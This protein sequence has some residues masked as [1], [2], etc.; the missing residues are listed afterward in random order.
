MDLQMKKIP[1]TVLLTLMLGLL[2]GTVLAEAPPAPDL[3][4]GSGTFLSEESRTAEKRPGAAEILQSSFVYGKEVP[5][6]SYRSFTNDSVPK[7]LYKPRDSGEDTYQE[8][9][10]QAVG[11]YT[12]KVIYPETDTHLE[13]A[14]TADFTIKAY[15]SGLQLLPGATL[16]GRVY[17]GSTNNVPLPPELPLDFTLEG[18]DR[19]PRLGED[20]EISAH[21]L[22][23]QVD[24][25]P[26]SKNVLL[27][28]SFI[29]ELYEAAPELKRELSLHGD[30]LKAPL[31]VTAKDQYAK[32][33]WAQDLNQVSLQGLAQ[34]DSLREI[35]LSLDDSRLVPEGAKILRGQEDVTDQYT[36]AYQPGH[37]H[38]SASIELFPAAA[39]DLFYNGQPQTLLN[40]PGKAENGVLMYRVSHSASQ[41]LPPSLISDWSEALP[42]GIAPGIYTVQFLA[43]NPNLHDSEEGSL[44][45]I[46]SPRILTITA[47][48]E[49]IYDGT[50]D[51]PE[52][53]ITITVDESQILP[54]EQVSVKTISG[55]SYESSLA[56]DRVKVIPGTV[57]LEGADGG[58][59]SVTLQSFTGRILKRPVTV[60]PREGEKHYGQQDPEISYQVQGLLKGEQLAGS[61]SRQPGEN[62]GSY[63]ITPGSL[64]GENNPNY[65]IRYHPE[66]FTIK[67][68]QGTL[69]MDFS[70][71]RIRPGR[72]LTIT[73]TARNQEKN[74]LPGG[75]AQPEEI[76]LQAMD[77]D[78]PLTYLGDG[79]WQ[80]EYKA[81]RDLKQS[82]S[83]R[84]SLL[85]NNYVPREISKEIP[86]SLPGANP[87]TGD[88]IRLYGSLLAGS[89]LLLL[90]LVLYLKRRK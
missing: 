76:A 63:A 75:W 21:Y 1:I 28:L 5:S 10:P 3:P 67:P 14:A 44:Q 81:P 39:E 33:G 8:T 38:R 55:S 64:N 58:N 16:P 43:R 79:Q 19:P 52:E 74:L 32:E 87:I 68:A 59:Y 65:Q 24:R 48:A 69:S 6:P 49:K 61:L 46:L 45:V 30:I 57:V 83:F 27:T 88:P 4:V 20:Y 82:L 47:E 84:L 34:G 51:L 25:D 17:N 12:V 35:R 85:D 29:G 72:D 77:Q 7:I 53:N 15:I 90:F 62:A 23:P 40:E 22:S 54:G 66:T 56:G 37:L 11:H 86:P 18:T 70:R 2:P 60:I 71:K 9:V 89:T 78:L 50:R 73:L 13:A 36:I 42:T 41:A 26:E 31:T 80:A